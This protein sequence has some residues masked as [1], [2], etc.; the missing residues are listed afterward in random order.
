MFFPYLEL[1]FVQGGVDLT[2]N[3]ITSKLP[4]LILIIKKSTQ[5]VS[6]DFFDFESHL[7]MPC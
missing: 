7:L 6:V 5:P 4:S 3:A 2:I 1:L